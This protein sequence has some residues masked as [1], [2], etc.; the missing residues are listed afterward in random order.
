M[1][2]LERRSFPVAELRAVEGNEP[3]IVGHAAVFETLSE[4]MWGFREKIAKGAFSDTLGAD[5][6]ALWN[7]DANIVL[8]RTVAGTLR[9][10]E[11][12]KGLAVEIDPPDTQA[13]RDL[14]VSIERGDVSQMSFGF[15][16]EKESWEFVK[17][18]PDIRTIE[19]VNLF[20]VSPVTYP[21]YTD[22]DVGL[23]E[24]AERR[25]AL[26]ADK[27]DDPA[28]IAR[29]SLTEKIRATSIDLTEKQLAQ[30]GR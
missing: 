12:D 16:V 4:E 11:D 2:T 3:K 28:D 22:T 26:R 14:L 19:K 24:A 29:K 8:G 23:R 15:F 17:D 5:V 6:R 1:P 27:P 7:H 10:A 13:A 20:D 25:D 30:A 9:L 18:G 21:A